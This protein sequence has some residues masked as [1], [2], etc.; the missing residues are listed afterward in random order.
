MW[1]Y[2]LWN[3]GNY[4]KDVDGRRYNNTRY[5]PDDLAEGNRHDIVWMPVVYAGLSWDN[6]KQQ[7]PG[8]T[9]R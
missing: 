1:G 7:P 2:S 5:W 8:A 4:L 9:K 6:L 3:P